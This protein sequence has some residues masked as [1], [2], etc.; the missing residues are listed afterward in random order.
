MKGANE[1]GANENGANEND[2]NEIINKFNS[3]KVSHPIITQLWLC[4][5]EL[6]KENYNEKLIQQC[7][8]VL[9]LLEN[10]QHD[11]N[12]KD[13]VSLLLYKKVML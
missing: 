8:Y 6:K 7:Y 3:Y 4:Y 13:I 11:L 12:Q 9:N 5:L 1:N 10:G 2:A